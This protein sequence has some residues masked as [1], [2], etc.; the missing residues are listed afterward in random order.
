[1]KKEEEDGIRGWKEKNERKSRE[2]E[3]RMW[4]EE[5]S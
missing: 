1:M 2:E 3:V 4:M 5:W